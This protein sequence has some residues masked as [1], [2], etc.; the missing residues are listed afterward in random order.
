MHFLM[1][2]QNDALATYCFFFNNKMF[3]SKATYCYLH[4]E[5]TSN[6]TIIVRNWLANTAASHGSRHGWSPEP[7][8]IYG[9]RD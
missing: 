7:A 9:Q 2:L 8:R 5:R 6:H 3:Y 1:A 4:A